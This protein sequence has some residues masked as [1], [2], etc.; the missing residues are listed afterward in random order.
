M[1]T[2]H[3]YPL[4]SYWSAKRRVNHCGC[5]D[6]GHSGEQRSPSQQQSEPL[7]SHTR[8][9]DIPDYYSS[10]RVPASSLNCPA[11]V[12]RVSPAPC[13]CS[14]LS[15]KVAW[16]GWIHNGKEGQLTGAKHKEVVFPKEQIKLRHSF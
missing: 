16:T 14:V 8:G 12:A 3:E 7:G 15:S 11:S 6:E 2:A 4:Y 1:C 5:Q 13:L 10:Y 9:T